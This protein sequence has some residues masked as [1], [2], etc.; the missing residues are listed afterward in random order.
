MESNY[1]ITNKSYQQRVHNTF[2][3][4]DKKER[5]P[6]QQST[7]KIDKSKGEILNSPLSE[8]TNGKKG[9]SINKY[10]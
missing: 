6:T 1:D 5:K 3:S 10:L 2:K 4:G 9:S 8:E 7:K